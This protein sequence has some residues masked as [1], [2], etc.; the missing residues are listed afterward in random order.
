MKTQQRASLGEIVAGM[1]TAGALPAGLLAGLGD[2]FSPVGAWAAPLLAGVAAMVV[3]VLFCAYRNLRR[4]VLPKVFGRARAHLWAEPFFRSPAFWSLLVFAVA[5]IVFGSV[6]RERREQGG[7]LA[8]NL[9]SVSELQEMSG[10]ARHSLEEQQRTRAGVDQLV[11]ISQ[12][13]AA[14]NP[15]VTLANRGVAW[16]RDSLDDALVNGDMET[17]ALFVEGGMPLAG[18]IGNASNLSRFFRDYSPQ[19]AAFIVAHADQVPDK[20]CLPMGVGFSGSLRDWLVDDERLAFYADLCN[21]PGVKAELQGYVST[22][23][24]SRAQAGTAAASVR[25]DRSACRTRLRREFGMERAM[26]LGFPPSIDGNSTIDAPEERVAAGLALLLNK[27][28]LNDAGLVEGYG[29]LIDTACDES[30]VARQPSTA[31][32]FYERVLAAF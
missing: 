17:V 22:F 11:G 27:P 15:R 10:I 31:D 2:F 13:G 6:S 7:W 16:N 25:S 4:A 9:A 12:T 26:Q 23:N 5:G 19:V 3:L 18:S 1:F 8:A 28:G 32:N 30:F 20:A 29:K 24:E 21:R 14:S